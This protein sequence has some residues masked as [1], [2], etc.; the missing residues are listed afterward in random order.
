MWSYISAFIVMD[1][2]CGLLICES[3]IQSYSESIV[4]CRVFSQ[5]TQLVSSMNNVISKRRGSILSVYVTEREK[6]PSILWRIVLGTRRL[7]LR[8]WIEKGWRWKRLVCFPLR[9]F[10]DLVEQLWILG[11]IGLGVDCHPRLG[12]LMFLFFHELWVF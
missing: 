6:H 4:N 1:E 5:N 2:L 9:C 11:G 7:G 12:L 8:S 3:L 10:H